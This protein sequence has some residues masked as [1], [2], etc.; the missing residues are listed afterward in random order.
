MPFVNTQRAVFR[1][2]NA[3]WA[4]QNPRTFP[5]GV[6]NVARL[7]GC[8]GAVRICFRRLRFGSCFAFPGFRHRKAG[9]IGAGKSGQFAQLNAAHEAPRNQE[10]ATDGI[11]QRADENP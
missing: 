11:T 2:D 5:A 4:A 9:S 10:A 6:L 7:R 1:F 8:G 3:G